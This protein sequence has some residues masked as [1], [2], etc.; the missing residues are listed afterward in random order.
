MMRCLNQ[1][2]TL[3]GHATKTILHLATPPCPNTMATLT[4]TARRKCSKSHL[5]TPLHSSQCDPLQ[6]LSSK[7]QLKQTLN[8]FRLIS[9]TMTV[10]RTHKLS[11]RSTSYTC[12]RN[13]G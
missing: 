9:R 13:V 7:Q 12:A 2:G 1:S 10:E 3:F 11:A 8:Q 4:L 6:T 5:A